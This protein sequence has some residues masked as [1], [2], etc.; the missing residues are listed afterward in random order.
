MDSSDGAQKQVQMTVRKKKKRQAAPI[1]ATMYQALLDQLDKTTLEAQRSQDNTISAL[2]QA[3]TEIRALRA[4]VESLQASQGSLAGNLD[5]TTS[6]VA[7]CEITLHQHG[8]QLHD[9]Q[10]RQATMTSQWD[11]FQQK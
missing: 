4:Q 3:M 5:L 2:D 7:T 11:A 1:D 9:V 10:Q 8:Q 6:R